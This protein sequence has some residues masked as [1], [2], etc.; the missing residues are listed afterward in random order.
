MELTS[1]ILKNLG[2]YIA[3]NPKDAVNKLSSQLLSTAE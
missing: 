1:E 2:N 3:V